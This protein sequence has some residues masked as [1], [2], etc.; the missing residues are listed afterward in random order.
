MHVTGGY[1]ET[2]AE[3]ETGADRTDE[4]PRLNLDGDLF[5]GQKGDVE[6]GKTSNVDPAQVPG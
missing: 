2:K 1:Y 4:G 6:E 5:G 3:A